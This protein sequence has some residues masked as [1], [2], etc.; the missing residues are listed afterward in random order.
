MPESLTKKRIRKVFTNCLE[1]VKQGKEMNVKRE[2]LDAGYSK[3]S[4][5][6]GIIKKTKTWQKLLSEIDDEEILEKVKEI[7]K[8]EDKRSSLTAADMLL[9]LKDR[10]PAQKSKI[11]G[12]FDRISELEDIE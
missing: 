4:A 9:K 11:V 7:L 8:A 6:V 10:Y 1:N 12:L 3:T 5:S 2:M